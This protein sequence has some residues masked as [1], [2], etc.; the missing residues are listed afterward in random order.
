MTPA[1][2]RPG[3]NSTPP[4]VS[5]AAL[6]AESAI[7]RSASGVEAAQ[8]TTLTTSS[9]SLGPSMR[10][11]RLTDCIKNAA[12]GVV[13]VAAGIALPDEIVGQ[14]LD[15]K[16]VP[17]GGIAAGALVQGEHAL[18]FAAA[19]DTVGENLAAQNEDVVGGDGAAGED[20]R[21]RHR[22]RWI[23]DGQRS[24]GGFPAIFNG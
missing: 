24:C 10:P 16:G 21:Q 6:T 22:G 15:E 18:G 13:D 1:R 17:G 4:P 3:P 2:L 14:R 7:S 12:P 9:S 5:T 19:D 20:R 8:W 11:S 23:G